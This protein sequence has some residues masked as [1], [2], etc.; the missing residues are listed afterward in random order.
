VSW[1]FHLDPVH[2]LLEDIGLGGPIAAGAV[3]L[4]DLALASI[5]AREL[6][7][8]LKFSAGLAWLYLALATV[9]C[10]VQA[11]S[12][13]MDPLLRVFAA[14]VLALAVAQTMFI[15]VVDFV[16]GR[17]GKKPLLPLIRY[18]LLGATFLIAALAGLRA[19]GV[20]T[21]GVLA[22][23]AVVVGGAGAAVAEVLRQVGAGILV[24]YARPFEVGDFIQVLPLEKRGAVLSTDWRTTTI[25]TDNG[26]EWLLPN[27]DIVTHTV[28]NFGHGDR[29]CRRRVTFDGPYEVPPQSIRA[30]VLPALRDV[31]GLEGTPPPFV[32]VTDFRDSGITYALFFWT[33]RI[34][35]FERVEAECRAR[36]WYAFA[37]ARISFP[38]P[39][40]TLA[41]AD[42][43]TITLPVDRRAE[44]L[45][46]SALFKLLDA[47]ALRDLATIG[48]ESLYG[49]GEVVVMAGEIGAT[50]HVLFEGEVAVQS[51]LERREL[52][53]L[54]PGEFFG[55]MSVVTGA[56]RAATVVTTAPTRT[57]VIDEPQFKTILERHPQVADALGEI[58]ASRQADL[59]QL[60]EQKPTD[61]ARNRQLK[62][63]IMERI[64]GLF[65]FGA[66]E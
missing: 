40:R 17:N 47:D 20:T 7:R 55:E 34:A 57:F 12:E 41:M 15:L 13:G 28:L 6:R 48:T 14:V 50:M 37:R 60:V 44:A 24:Q 8:S 2:R 3:L 19:G 52:L 63:L 16:A 1:P 45:A 49:P 38:Y 21:F 58:L 25:R 65:S 61:S 18:G 26:V 59:T 10:F 29:P 9:R 53:R 11:S 27:N 51:P 33:K 39:V 43:P 23:G 35:D 46:N 64:K 32:E 54:G 30:V 36:V 56:P 62:S 42:P 4:A 66:K 5:L 31:E 22:S